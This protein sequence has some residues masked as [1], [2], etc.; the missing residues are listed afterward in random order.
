VAGVGLGVGR[1]EGRGGDERD[2]SEGLKIALGSVAGDGAGDEE[3]DVT[4]VPT[5][6]NVPPHCCVFL[7]HSWRIVYI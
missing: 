3:T 4:V 2:G 1:R 5:T 6:A 7:A